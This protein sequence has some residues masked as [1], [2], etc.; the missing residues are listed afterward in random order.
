MIAGYST[1]GPE[2]L[3]RA[4]QPVDTVLVPVV[5]SGL[6]AGLCAAVGDT[7]QVVPVELLQFPVLTRALEAGGSVD[8]AYT[9]ELVDGLSTGR[10]SPYAYR[11]ARRHAVSPVPVDERQHSEIHATLWDEIRVPVSLVGALGLAGMSAP[12]G[13]AAVAAILYGRA[14]LSRLSA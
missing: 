8:V 4:K 7:A 12:A 14:D 13:D 1:I 11:A 5:D 9:G 3:G 6:Y 10:V 2:L